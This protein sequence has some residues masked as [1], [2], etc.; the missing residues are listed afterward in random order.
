MW[1]LEYGAPS[2]VNLKSMF[3]HEI[4]HALG[5]EHTKGVRLGEP[6]KNVMAPTLPTTWVPFSDDEI[7][8]V[9]FLYGPPSSK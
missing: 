9:Q 7:A 6:G 8:S 1:S 3:T 2:Q 5:I 4:G